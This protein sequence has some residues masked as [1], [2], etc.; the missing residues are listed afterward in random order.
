MPTTE[1]NIGQ[2][3]FKHHFQNDLKE[4]QI[5][6][7]T[8][9][10][11]GRRLQ[12]PQTICSD[13]IVGQVSYENTIRSGGNERNRRKDVGLRDG[14]PPQMCFVSLGPTQHRTEIICKD[15]G[16]RH[17]KQ[18]TWS[19]ANPPALTRYIQYWIITRVN[20][21]H[22]HIVPPNT[23]FGQPAIRT[24]ARLEIA[25]ARPKLMEFNEPELIKLGRH[26]EVIKVRDIS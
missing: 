4:A 26:H 23:Y 22:L 25:I 20:H 19:L 5:I 24:H 6:N 3:R 12:H 2:Y 8:G 18:R 17:E 14:K 7:P 10:T 15:G 16:Q 1:R 13:T 21:E 11:V 9:Q